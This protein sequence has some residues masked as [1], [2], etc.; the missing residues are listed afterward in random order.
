MGDG[1]VVVDLIGGLLVYN[2]AAKRLIGAASVGISPE[3]WSRHYG[4]YLPDTVTPYPASELPLAQAMRGQ[5][6]DAA[7]IFVRNGCVPQGA[8]VSSTS[9]PLRDKSGNI[10]GGVTVFRDITER[11]RAEQSMRDSERSYRLLFEK[12]RAGILR[13]TEDGKILACN[14]GFARMLGFASTEELLGLQMQDFYLEPQHRQ[15][16]LAALGKTG[17]LPDQEFSFKRLDGGHAFAIAN[18]NLIDAASGESGRNILG[19]MI[20][21]TERKHWEESLRRSEEQF[22]SFMRHLPGV[23]FRKDLSG[24]YVYIGETRA[25]PMQLNPDAINKLDEEIWPR[26][27]AAR[28]RENDERVHSTGQPVETIEALPQNDGPHFWLMC[29]FPILDETGRIAFL[30]G[31]GIDVT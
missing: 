29:R 16:I 5:P 30:G 3:D 27:V 21:I 19:T 13:T 24:R 2:A 7:E 14:D 31:I 9:R 12:N 23:A 1:V 18:L 8:W 4:F 22:S 11:K 15:T 10:R 17:F 6:V 25:A 20:D 26:D 28:L